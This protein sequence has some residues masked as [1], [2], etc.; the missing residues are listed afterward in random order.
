MFSVSAKF[1]V[2]NMHGSQ[3]LGV[4]MR[5][6]GFQ[7]PFVCYEALILHFRG[8]WKLLTGLVLRF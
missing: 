8:T 3:L 5:T 2:Q 1:S 7:I 6:Y 4:A